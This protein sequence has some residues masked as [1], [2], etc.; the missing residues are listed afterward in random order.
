[1]LRGCEGGVYCLIVKVFCVVICCDFLWVYVFCGMCF[2]CG[3]GRQACGVVGVVH[4]AM[5]FMACD[6]CLVVCW[7]LLHQLC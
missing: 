4:C 2:V 3:N 1:M 5:L 6:V 7:V